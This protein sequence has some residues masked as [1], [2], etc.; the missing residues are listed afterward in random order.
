MTIFDDPAKGCFAEK[1]FDESS[2]ST[3]LQ[4]I[5]ERLMEASE[6]HREDKEK[7]WE[8]KS[9]EFQSYQG[10][11]AAT[12]CVQTTVGGNVVH[13]DKGCTK[14]YLRRKSRRMQI[15]IHEHYLPADTTQAKAVIVELD[16]PPALAAYRNITW[17]IATSLARTA[18]LSGCQTRSIEPKQRLSEYRPL[19]NYAI[20]QDGVGLASTTKSFLSTHYS[21]IRFPTDLES[22]C[23]PNGLKLRY[24]DLGSCTW[25]GNRTSPP[26]FAHLCQIL[27]PPQSPFAVLQ[28]VT[29]SMLTSNGPLSNEVIARQFQSPAG[30]NA[31]EYMAF[32]TLC[33]GIHRRWANLLVELGSS[34][35]NF[36]KDETMLLVRQVV[37]HAGPGNGTTLR[38]AHQAFLDANFRSRLT[39]VIGERLSVIATNWREHNS[40]ET[41]ITLLLRLTSLVTTPT[42]AMSLLH[43][44]RSVV[45]GWT[46]ELRKEIHSA[47]GADTCRTYSQYALWAA[48]LGRRT[49][50]HHLETKN[51]FKPAELGIFVECSISLQDNFETSMVQVPTL[52]SALIRD[53]GMAYKMRDLLQ[54]SLKNHVGNL[55][56]TI[57]T[58]WPHGVSSRV[59]TEPQFKDYHWVELQTVA[60]KET[61]SQTIH[62]NWLEG[63]LLI[64][65]EPLGR[66]PAEHR[67]NCVLREL[68]GNES[69]L[70]YPSGLT[71][72]MYVVTRNTR[73]H[74]VHIG[75]HSG[76]M[77]VQARR[78]GQVLEF[79]HRS[80]FVDDYGA[81]LP[82]SLLDNCVHW[83]DVATGIIEIRR[84]PDIWERKQGNWVVDLSKEI[85]WR[86]SSTLVDPSSPLF[87]IIASI[88]EHFEPR[89]ELTV[90]QA[91]SGNIHVDLPRL[92]LNFMIIRH[93]RLYCREL[94][95][96]IDPNQDASTWYGL[97]SKLVLQ[98]A[99]NPSLRNI[100]TPLGDIQY[101]LR[102]GDIHV[103][104]FLQLSGD[105]GRFFI[106][107]TLGR[108]ECAAE[109]RLLLA[110]AMIHAYTSMIIP[111]PLT[112][113]TGTEEAIHCLNSGISQPWTTV[114][115]VCYQS[116]QAIARLVPVRSYYPQ[117][118]KVMQNIEW[119]PKM[120]STIQQDA[121]FPPLMSILASLQRLALF[122]S[123]KS[124]FPDLAIKSHAHLRLRG[125]VRR[126]VYERLLG[127]DDNLRVIDARYEPRDNPNNSRSRSNVFETIALLRQWPAALPTTK[128]LGGLLQCPLVG[129]FET[130][131]ECP[132]LSSLLELNLPSEFGALSRRCAQS[133]YKTRHDLYFLLGTIAF[134]EDA[135]M[136]LVRVLI[137]F[138]VKHEL[139]DLVP[140]DFPSFSNFRMD[141]VPRIDTLLRLIDSCKA[142]YIDPLAEVSDMLTVNSRKKIKKAKAQ[143]EL[144]FQEQARKLANHILE[145][146]PCAEPSIDGVFEADQ[147]PPLL[148]VSQ[149]LA[150]TLP[151]WLRL[152]QNFQLSEYLSKV[153][154]VLDASCELQFE[155][156]P[157]SKKVESIA[158]V[159]LH[160]FKDLCSVSANLLQKHCP[161]FT[162][163]AK[164]RD[165]VKAIVL[166]EDGD[167]QSAYSNEMVQL[168]TII[169]EASQSQSTVRQKYA[170][171]L[172]RS[173]NALKGVRL[174]PSHSQGTTH[175]AWV[176]KAIAQ[177][178]QEMDGH[179]VRITAALH[180]SDPQIPW[181]AKSGL[182]P[183][184][185]TRTLLEQLRSTSNAI[186]GAGIKE[187]FIDFAL[188][189]T[190][191]QRLLRIEAAQLVGNS[192]ALAEELANEG[193][194][195]WISFEYPDWLLLEIVSDILIR[196]A[197][198][199]VARATISP[200]SGSNSVLQL[201]MG[202]G[203]TSVIIPMVAAVLS[204]SKRLVRVVVLKALLLQTAQLMQTRLGCLLGRRIQHVPFS[205]KTS[206]SRQT[207]QGYH[208]IH[209]ETMA[210]A[211]IMITL[212]EHLMSFMLSGLQR[213]SDAKLEE[214]RS[215]IKLQD[216]LRRVSR[217]ILDECDALL[218]TRT[219]LIYPSG[220]QST[221][222]GHPR[223]WET[224][225]AILRQVQAHLNSLEKLYPHSIEVLRRGTDSERFPMV[226]LLR[227]D[228]ED[229]LLTRIISDI[230]CEESGI[231]AIQQCT[232]V[233]RQAIREFISKPIIEA[234]TLEHLHQMTLF[235]ENNA[236]KNSLYLI[237]G[238]IVH[239]ILLLVLKKRWNVQYGLHPN[240]DPMA[241]P[242]LAKGVPSDQA[243]WGHPDVAILFTCL[244]FYFGGLTISHLKQALQHLGKADDPS[245]QYHRWMQTAPN[246]PSQLGYWNVINV[247][248]ELQLSELW[249]HLGFNIVVIDYFL[250]NL[251]FPKHAKQFK[252]KL[253]ASGW[254]IHLLTLTQDNRQRQ[255][256][257]TTGFSGTNDSRTMLPLTIKQEDLS[258]LAHTNAEVL[259][260]LLLP[261]NRRY[262]PAMD[263]DGRRHSEER[264][265]RMLESEN[266]RI[267]IDA[268]AHVLEM[269]NHSLAK[270]WLRVHPEPRAA[271]YFGVD[272]RA[273]ILYR[274]GKTMP[275]LASPFAD[276]LSEVLVYLGESH[277]RGTDLKLPPTSV[278]ALTLG[279]GQTKDH[280]VQGKIRR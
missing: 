87:G 29:D 138:A 141:V 90:Y 171:D 163:A 11:I 20:P 13:D 66:L 85:A 148:N 115:P 52:R 174:Q 248:D 3:G 116:L 250:S 79:I 53:L 23:R 233:D 8:E 125:H 269:D 15:N 265:L 106:N 263:D 118:M 1:Y 101:F 147:G 152:V 249:K 114:H 180:G 134:S 120:N 122:S 176:P 55:T 144:A 270:A 244:S 267:L 36:S 241:V 149:A 137:A 133:S 99:R 107:Q 64:D 160:H 183:C 45:L 185:T 84:K 154:E 104:S 27:L 236:A 167:A 32:Q 60:T 165:P 255:K 77:I 47:K 187:A 221:V 58:L 211:G 186:F 203:K 278:A 43:Q 204:N 158:H 178:Q 135:N 229:A 28:N 159:S 7:E 181:L 262:M 19:I 62:Y 208:D 102:P 82:G 161:R 17:R 80:R 41:I 243:E 71:H 179:Q 78:K 215:M 35:L 225:Q 170:A 123:E 237:R 190:A 246:I 218:A 48:L 155:V 172:Q 65:N 242:F 191:L 210:A 273:N 81:D 168:N 56:E 93:G 173:L 142:E 182:L 145:Q 234:Q 157:S 231:L 151:E 238:L 54:R 228:V 245:S 108:V 258:N 73:G 40:M 4:D 67:K 264:L 16:C 112:G 96:I 2:E 88:F 219:Q 119:D 105:Y 127:G 26:S 121:I 277:C 261:R 50:A 214:A 199:D 195:N 150:L 271:L 117:G 91:K 202:Q 46:R 205:R 130:K 169:K 217:D 38:K 247:N 140:P 63:T 198:V 164:V 260:Y 201:N 98:D 275:L 206:T 109:P 177:A 162:M 224:A 94:R 132:L 14:C 76:D 223:R 42:V 272:N 33:S 59:Y 239:R 86:R 256:P 212:P 12:A 9:A 22:V 230:L 207:L 24:Y 192:K 21:S 276:D 72:M 240:R 268:G 175:L 257:L 252:V 111:D 89:R 235:K 213:L 153:Q 100:I 254:D 216:W 280:T 5:Y 184:L 253:Q 156:S 166:L 39:D 188:S 75:F 51:E 189:V 136:D 97:V 197:Q 57:D 194:E 25:T 34:N 44:A 68:F 95:S 232:E 30:L 10:Q 251:V 103:T 139:K 129:G 128:D 18:D 226:F 222:D 49:Y 74:E 209:V 6:E 69:P 37:S 193:H 70:I 124:G 227:N 31:H 143:S 266:I 92:E 200:S 126:R 279:L 196:S 131:F 259:S 146:W 83:L 113:R 220:Q 110:K 61:K 274:N